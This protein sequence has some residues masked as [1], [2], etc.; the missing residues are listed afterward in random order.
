MAFGCSSSFGS[1]W[2]FAYPKW[3]VFHSHTRAPVYHFSKTNIASRQKFPLSMSEFESAIPS[4]RIWQE[5]EHYRLMECEFGS[6]YLWCIFKHYQPTQEYTL[7]L[8]RYNLKLEQWNFARN[9]VYS[10]RYFNNSLLIAAQNYNRIQIQEC[11]MNQNCKVM[12]TFSNVGCLEI[13]HGDSSKMVSQNFH[14][15]NN[16]VLKSPTEYLMMNLISGTW[17][18]YLEKSNYV[19]N[20]YKWRE[21]SN[22]VASKQAQKKQYTTWENICH[23]S[24]VIL[25]LSVLHFFFRLKFYH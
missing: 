19:L 14:V 7:E 10:I 17:T 18:R 3:E 23:L 16:W 2:E 24:I 22:Q 5:Y 20:P 13:Q 25:L 1:T 8:H 6:H 9:N 15:G 11:D 12:P 4:N 21:E